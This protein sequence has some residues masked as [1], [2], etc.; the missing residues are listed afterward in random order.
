[1]RVDVTPPGELGPWSVATLYPKRGPALTFRVTTFDPCREWT[2]VTRVLWF[3]VRWRHT[4]EP[5]AEGGTRLAV[6]VEV[7]GPLDGLGA[8]VAASL[9]RRGLNRALPRLARELDAAGA[10]V[11]GAPA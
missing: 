2:W 9:T 1:V 5:R 6:E 7:L 10:A 11:L 8:R 4:F 3:D